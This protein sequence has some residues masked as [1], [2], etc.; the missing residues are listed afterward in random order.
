MISPKHC[1][2]RGEAPRLG[3][4]LNAHWLLLLSRNKP[5]VK[6]RIPAVS[7]SPFPCEAAIRTGTRSSSGLLLRLAVSF[8]TAI[9]KIIFYVSNVIHRPEVSAYCG[10]VFSCED[11]SCGLLSPVRSEAR[12]HLS[13]TYSGLLEING[14]KEN[15]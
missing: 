6:S 15:H 5:G 8:V 1:F 13:E 7:V 3:S 9:K 11:S 4:V 10:A 2:P 12:K 14:R